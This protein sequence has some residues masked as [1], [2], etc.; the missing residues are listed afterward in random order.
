M[1]DFHGSRKTIQAAV[2]TVA[3]AITPAHAA[4]EQRP[5]AAAVRPLYQAGALFVDVRTDEEWAAGHLKT[6]IHLPVDQ[7]SDK[8]GSVLP[9][10]TKPIVTYCRSGARAQK[11]AG[12]LRELGYTHVTAMTGGYDDL[13]AAGYSV[14][15]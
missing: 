13:K 8:A 2:L 7:V 4:D 12:I 5:N 9:D 3:A 10:K 15:P 6:A 14:A 11:A 1:N